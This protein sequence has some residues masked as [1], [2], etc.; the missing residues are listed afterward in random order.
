MELY[1][2]R[3]FVTVAELRHLTRAA[4][5]LHISQPA[6]SAQ[7]KSLE[8]ELGVALFDR[9][10]GGMVLTAAGRRLLTGAE[11]VLA[12]AQTLRNEAL[13][14]KGEVAGTAR[15]G[16][17]S[18]P[19]L[20]R[21]GEFMTATVE[22]YPLL[23]LELHHAISGEAFELVCSGGL[24]ASF[25]FGPLS[26]PNVTG[27]A[28][29]EITYRVVAPAA[30]Q[31]RIAHAEWREI[32]ALPWIITPSI[33]T[34]NQLVMALFRDEGLEPTKVIEADQEAVI[35]TL[36]VA[37]VGLAL[38]REDLVRQKAVEGQICFWKDV[39]ATTTLWFIYA[40]A[41]EHDLVIA[42]LL[43]VLRETWQLADMSA[44]ATPRRSYV[45]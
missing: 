39:G 27:L 22:R 21:L 44:A 16:T 36:V 45:P 11:K 20:I 28:L 3:S 14:L 10:P 19:A 34:H 35:S 29:R 12:A 5:K 8:D 24:D 31:E 43:D 25:Y 32:A 1:Q 41:R 42:A 18:D 4:E 38:L 30:W 2:L 37:G 17:H 40:T 6:L 7:I 23:Q 26:H 13:A 15:V 9:T 33:S